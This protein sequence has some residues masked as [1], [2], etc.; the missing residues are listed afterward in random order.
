VHAAQE[1]VGRQILLENP[2]AYLSFS[3]SEMPEWEFL[4]VLC[5]QTGCGLLLD[6]NNVY[7]SAR[8]LGFDPAAY[9]ARFPLDHVRQIH[10]AGHSQGED[11]LI[12]THDQTVCDEVWDLFE[13]AMT[14]AGPVAVMIERDDNIPPI[15]DLLDELA[16]A[17][18]R[19]EAA[20]KRR[21]Q[22]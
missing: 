15:G 8:N 14:R 2:S 17:R 22:P 4:S 16:T 21:S 7:V 1:I 5:G 6:V 13:T 18:M 9:I 3:Q 12:D 19:A 20:T 11:L 10:I